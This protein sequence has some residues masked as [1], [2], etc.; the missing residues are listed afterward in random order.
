MWSCCAKSLAATPD[1]F[2]TRSKVCRI[3]VLENSS[4][5]STFALKNIG[6][7]VTFGPAISPFW[8]LSACFRSVHQIKI[9][10]FDEEERR[11]SYVLFAGHTPKPL[12]QNT[13]FARVFPLGDEIY[14]LHVYVLEVR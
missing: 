5:S 1:L 10:R 11:G 2:C 6:A 12:P 8:T 3:L 7:G 4:L 13:R 9:F 14:A